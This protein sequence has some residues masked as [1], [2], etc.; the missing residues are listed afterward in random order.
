MITADA[1]DRYEFLVKWICFAGEIVNRPGVDN[2]LYIAWVT[3]DVKLAN[4]LRSFL[5]LPEFSDSA[6]AHKVKELADGGVAKSVRDRMSA[7]P[8]RG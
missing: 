6:L 3:E 7:R 4:Q 8:K 2:R 5:A 1:Y